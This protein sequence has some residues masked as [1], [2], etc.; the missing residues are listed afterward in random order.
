VFLE[1]NAAGSVRTVSLAALA[2]G[3][4]PE[5]AVDSTAVADG[6]QIAVGSA[7]GY[8]AVWRKSSGGTWTL[9]SSLSLAQSLGGADP[10][11]T[12]LTSVTH[13]AAGWLAVGAP[14][15]V[16]LTS[17]NGADWQIAAGGITQGLAGVGAVAA[18][19][20]PDGYVIV[21]KLV[22]P[23]GACV[24]DVW[25]SP[26]LTS[27]TRAHDVNDATG[28][29]QVLAVAAGAH[30]FVSVG[31][32][33]AKPTVWT[34]AN[35]RS[36]ETIVL[37][38]P[39]GATAATLEQVAIKGNRVTALGQVTTAAGPVPFAE[40]SV[41]GGV[42]WQQVPFSSPGP[43]TAFTALAADSAGFT[44]AGLFGE[45]GQ[46]NVAVWTS[47]TGTSWTPTQAS[48]F[49][50]AGAW[51]ISA[52]APSGSAVA[53]I[54]SITTQQSQQTVTLTLPARSRGSA[55]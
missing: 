27:W 42:S 6:Q 31:S 45:P 15:P 17:A 51:Q 18:A 46:Q 24:A 12:A 34:T 43:D 52:L 14:G 1:A 49:S 38:V 4:V 23:G 16:I 25:W 33:E 3:T 35:G 20:G 22:A 29:S 32:H 47:A 50:G 10:G 21:G 7:D 5:V 28:S 36:W 9:V 41:D 19:S 54:G 8:P 37:P 53:G 11:L 39:D 55:R 2:G 13:G 40:L 30:G 44:A 26:N 48:D